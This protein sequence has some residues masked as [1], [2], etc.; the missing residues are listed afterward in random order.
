MNSG[1]M[2][3]KA[4]IITDSNVPFVRAGIANGYFFFL[5]ILIFIFTGMLKQGST[6]I[7]GYSLLFLVLLYI[8]YS[9]VTSISKV[10]FY[11][12]RIVIQASIATK[13]INIESIKKIKLAYAPLNYII[14]IKFSLKNQLLPSSYGFVIWEKTNFGPY[15]QTLKKI[16][17]ILIGY[18]KPYRKST[19]LTKVFKRLL[20]KHLNNSSS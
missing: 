19:D 1:S 18:G 8:I 7:I 6:S 17:N 9:Y 14:T 15:S 2:K 10:L 4:L 16:E 20:G 5:A 13:T 3:N 12:D 11:S